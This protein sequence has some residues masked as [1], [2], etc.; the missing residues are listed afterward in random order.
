MPL[1]VTDRIIAS[2][3][4][5]EPRIRVL[6]YGDI[7]ADCLIHKRPPLDHPLPHLVLVFPGLLDVVVVC[8]SDSAEYYGLERC[9]VLPESVEH[10]AEIGYILDRVA[11]VADGGVEDPHRQ[12]GCRSDLRLHFV[13]VILVLLLG[14]VPFNLANLGEFAG[15]GGDSLGAGFVDGLHEFEIWIVAGAGTRGGAPEH[16]VL[17]RGMRALADQPLGEETGGEFRP[18]RQ[19]QQRRVTLGVD[20][21]PDAGRRGHGL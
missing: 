21:F 12:V 17:L 1:P 18:L 7:Q 14:V 5:R 9:I 11:V 20:V 3:R 8:S 15:V 2:V 19:P 4:S 6:G 16:P 13:P 10:A